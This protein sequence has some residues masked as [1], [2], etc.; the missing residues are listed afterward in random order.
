[1]WPLLT[2]ARLVLARPGGQQ[3]P[4][5]LRQVIVDEGV[6]TLHFVPSMLAAFLE[7][8]D[9]SACRSLRRL[10]CSGEALPPDA[11]RRCLDRLPWVELHNLYGPTEAAVDVTAWP[12]H[13]EEAAGGVPIGRP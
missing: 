2:G 4:G 5:Y 11:V 10:L 7:E 12:C 9:L 6:T 3:D 8:P 13:A 1:F